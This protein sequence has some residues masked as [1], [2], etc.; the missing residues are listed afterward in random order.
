MVIYIYIYI[1]YFGKKKK[2]SNLITHTM[3]VCGALMALFKL[4]FESI[5]TNEETIR[6]AIIYFLIPI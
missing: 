6:G 5:I 4:K 1:E 2:V 3:E